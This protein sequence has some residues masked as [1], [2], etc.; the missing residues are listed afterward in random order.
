MTQSL[1]RLVV[2]VHVGDLERR[3]TRN[4]LLVA[5]NGEPVVL[6]GDQDT[7]GLQLANGMIPAPMPVG[8]LRCPSAE[9]E[10]QELMSQ[11][12]TEHRHLALGD[13]A[14]GTRRV[15]D[16]IR[17]AGAVREEHAVWIQLE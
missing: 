5:L 7:P 4:T 9:R 13:R 1:Y 14:D 16:R 6:R 12:D 11:A 3:R 8:H 17:V 15:F 2:Q 10:S